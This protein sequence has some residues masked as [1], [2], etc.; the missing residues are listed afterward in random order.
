MARVRG[1]A[2]PNTIAAVLLHIRD[3]TGKIPHCYFTWAEGNPL[4]YILRF[5]LLGQ[6]DTPPV[7]N[8][9]MRQAE[10]DPE[11][12]PALHVGGWG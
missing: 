6:G 2:V 10:P 11:R 9:V 1:T 8:Q 7:T 12:R 3:V 4:A 5:L